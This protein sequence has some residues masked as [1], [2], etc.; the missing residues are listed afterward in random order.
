MKRFVDGMCDIF[1]VPSNDRCLLPRANRKD[2]EKYPQRNLVETV[3]SIMIRKFRESL[4]AR[5]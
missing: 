5:K 4:K 3:F 2:Q 1:F